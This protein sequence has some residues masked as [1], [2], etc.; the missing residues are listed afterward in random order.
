[1]VRMF[2]RTLRK[3]TDVKFVLIVIFRPKLLNN[4]IH[5]IEGYN[6][7]KK[8]FR[9]ERYRYHS[10]LSKY[11]WELHEEGKEYKIEWSIIRKINSSTCFNFCKLCL[12]EKYFILNALGDCQLLNKKF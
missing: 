7:H 11:I 4:L 5:I 2:S 9:H 12:T 10:E 1:M 6:N 3:S 8:S